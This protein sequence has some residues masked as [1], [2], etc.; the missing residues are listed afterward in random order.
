MKQTR[1]FFQHNL[2]TGC[3]NCVTACALARSGACAEASALI[4]V[5][6]DPDF[7]YPQPLLTAACLVTACENECEQACMLRVLKVAESE[8]FQRLM[9]DARWQPV[10]IIPDLRGSK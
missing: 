10:P 5:P 7:G 3:Q 4:R 2:C 1:L 8:Q 6:V 9:D